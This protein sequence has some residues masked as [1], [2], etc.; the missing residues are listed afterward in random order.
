MAGFDWLELIRIIVP[1]VIELVKP[2]LQPM[3]N[4]ISTAINSVEETSSGQAG[5][6]KLHK[7]LNL[8][9]P[10]EDTEQDVKDVINK[11]I[12]LVNKLK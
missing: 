8:I 6:I 4:T 9:A 10:T 3:S 12:S 5:D 11:S 7:A 2:Q 1:V